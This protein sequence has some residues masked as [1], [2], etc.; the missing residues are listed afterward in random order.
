MFAFYCTVSVLVWTKTSCWHLL[1][2]LKKDIENV[3]GKIIPRYLYAYN[4]AERKC[5][6]FVI[7]SR[8]TINFISLIASSAIHIVTIYFYTN[9]LKATL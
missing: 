5:I 3:I 4:Y 2:N 6:K 8:D 9:L 1:I 7:V